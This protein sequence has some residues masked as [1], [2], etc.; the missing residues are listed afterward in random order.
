M[1]SFLIPKKNANHSFD[2]FLN[3]NEMLDNQELFKKIS[4]HQLKLKAKSRMIAAIYKSM[5]IKNS[6][7]KNCIK[8]EDYM[9]KT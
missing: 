5:L 4:K 2:N 7:F 3:K 1:I 9:K 8:L 6:L